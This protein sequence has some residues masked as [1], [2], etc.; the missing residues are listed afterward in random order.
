M[1]TTCMCHPVVLIF[2]FRYHVPARIRKHVDYITPGIKLLATGMRGHGGKGIQKRT[3][4][5]TGQRN[6]QP[7]LK[8]PLPMP[9]AAIAQS[10]VSAAPLS[11][12]DVAITPPCVKGTISQAFRD[13]DLML[14][15]KNSSLQCNRSDNK[16]CWE[17]SGNIRGSWG[18]L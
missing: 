17:Q 10:L 18:R 7:P 11:I 3:F 6:K 12:C 13:I 14:I 4:G 8:A 2:V 5:I 1:D 9:M 15:M 16:G